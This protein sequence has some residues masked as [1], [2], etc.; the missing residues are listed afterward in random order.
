MGRLLGLELNNFKSYRGKT[1]IGFGSSNFVSII[2]P[3]GSGKSNMMDAIS[4]VLGLNSTQL[5]SKH[6]R[7]LIYRGRKDTPV[8]LDDSGLDLEQD[9]RSA[10]VLAIYQKNDGEILRLKRSISTSGSTEYQINDQS[11][12][13]LNYTATLK[14]ENILVKARNFLVFQGDV[15]QI[16]SQNPKDLSAMIEHISGSNEYIEEYERLKDERD[17]AHE[18]TNEVFSRKRTLN[19]ESKQYKEQASE[20]RQFEKSLILRNDLVKKLNLYQLYHNENKHNQLK[21]EI[22]SKNDLLQEMKSELS[23]TEK[24][25]KSFTSEYSKISLESKSHAKQIEQS[26]Q[27]VESTKRGLIPLESNKVS[28]SSKLKSQENKVSDL[29]VD[30]ESQKAQIKKLEKQLGD[31]KKLFKDFEEQVRASIAASSSLNIPEEGQKEYEKLRAEYL[32]ASGSELEEHISLLMNEKDSLTIKE[33]SLISQKSNADLRIQDLQSSLNL[34]LK[35]KL[36]DLNNEIAQI[37]NKKEEKN[38]ARDKLIKQKDLFN[39]EEFQINTELKDVLLKLEELSSQQRESNKQKKL[40][41]NIST[42]KRL[43]PTGSIKG[44]VHEL[45]RPTEQKY[46]SALSTILGRNS[47]AIIVETATI[48]Y[49]CIDI[50][51]ERRAGVATFIPLDSVE[52]DPV[53]LSYLRSINDAAIPGMDIVEYEDKSLGPAV[54]YIVGN[55]LVAND[56][57]AARNI[58]WSSSRKFEN[59]IVTL[60]GSVIH[61]SGQMTGGQQIRRSS[62]NI[63]WSKQEWTKMSERKEALLSK[64]MKLQETRPKELEINLLAEEISSLDD[65]LPVLKNQKSSLERAINDKLSEIDFSKKQCEKFE[66]TLTEMKSDFKRIDGEISKTKKEIKEAKSAIY[67]DFCKKWKIKDG[68]EKYEELHGTAL[69]TRAKERSLFLKSISVLQNRLDFDAS[70]CEETESR[71]NVIKNQI[72]DLKDELNNVLEER[73]KLEDEL[74]IAQAENEVLKKEQKKIEQLLESKLKSSKIVETNLAEK[75]SE[76]AS[77]SKEI[78]EQEERLLK[79]DSIRA[80]VLKNCKIQNI[81]LPLEKGDLDHISMGED[82]DETLNEIY[83][84]EIDYEMLDDK[85]KETYSPKLEAE[86]EVMLQ[87]TIENLEKLTPNAKALERF[88][89]VENKLRGYDKDYTVARQNERKAADKFREISEKRYDK[90]MEA[91]NHISG[92]IDATYKE[93]TKS[94]LSPMGGSAFLILEDEDSPYS[95]GVKYHA[96]PPMKRFQDMEL[97]SGGEKTMAALALLFAIHSFQ[98]APFFVLDEIDAALDNN[99]V[100]KIGNYIRNHAGPNFQVIVI[101]LK[102]NLYEKSDALVGIYREQR[103]NSSKT[104]TLDLSEYPDEDQPLQGNPVVAV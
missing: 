55:A 49:K 20:Q 1:N 13:R 66:E 97:L 11:V 90:F 103:E 7:D 58:R 40:R 62:A 102:N 78:I 41:E 36:N 57:N 15:E 70:R 56:I 83:K 45:V 85:Y 81:I 67:Q 25:Y 47:D 104:V 59:K 19:S 17:R 12:T 65:Q 33:K 91:F 39:K 27:K 42:L 5:R 50:L 16:A 84:I 74:D 69:R 99:N 10:Y 21:K 31:S 94:S 71:R 68:I 95:S 44:L 52:F 29:E 2:G 87:N 89:E 3:N 63:S 86:L 14:Q 26:N 35:S 77:L 4:F 48:A 92:C 9:P 60:Q 54:E 73:K 28:L 6:L 43:L 79:L 38:A 34:E 8:D 80:N 75:S 18:V 32:A 98:P 72:V 93:L 88:K 76:V 64:V 30:I 61:K 22:R 46:E 51:K 82:S 101:S 53:N 23:K 37:L 24:L 96:M 100:A